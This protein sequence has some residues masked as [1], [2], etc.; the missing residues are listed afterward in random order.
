MTVINVKS[1][2]GETEQYDVDLSDSV[3]SLQI[4]IAERLS[5]HVSDVR[6]I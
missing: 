6:L 5:M 4:L 1:L 3:G 2:S